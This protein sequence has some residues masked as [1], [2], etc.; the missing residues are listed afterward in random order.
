MRTE[1]ASV[2]VLG[3]AFNVSERRGTTEVVLNSGKVA[4]YLKDEKVMMKPGE[5]VI[6]S[7]ELKKYEKKIVNPEEYTSWRKN[8]LI[9]DDTPLSEIAQLLQDNYG[10]DVSIENEEIGDK[11]FNGTVGT[12]QIDLLLSAIAEAHRISVTRKNGTVYFRS[13]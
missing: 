3:T 1:G 8:L 6:Y 12:D 9:F 10:F 4:F 11:L 13:R 5:Q 7:P 2:E